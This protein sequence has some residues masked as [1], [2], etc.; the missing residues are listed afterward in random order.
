M[1]GKQKHV[2]VSLGMKLSV[3][4]CLNQGET[5]KE[6]ASHI[7]VGEVTVGDW[8]RKRA[9]I[10]KLCSQRASVRDSENLSRKTMKKGEFEQTS[11]ALFLWFTQ[12][13]DKGSPISG[14][15]L[16]AMA[17]EFH[18]HFNKGTEQFTASIGW[19][20]IT[21]CIQIQFI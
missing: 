2:V 17:L 7:G 13:R 12:M 20:I 18:K 9:E 3:I 21:L 15:I 1:S 14:L 4:K 19:H 10:E 5:I 11:E 6:V 8:R 16:Q